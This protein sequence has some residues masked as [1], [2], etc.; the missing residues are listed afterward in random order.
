M[1][2]KDKKIRSFSSPCPVWEQPVV[3]GMSCVFFPCWY[4]R[5]RLLEVSLVSQEFLPRDKMTGTPHV[6]TERTT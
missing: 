1:S 2:A 3:R 6:L 5:G 4:L